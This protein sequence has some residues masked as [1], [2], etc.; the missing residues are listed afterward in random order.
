[1][2]EFMR[3]IATIDSHTAGE[4]TR[5]ITSGLPFISGTTMAEKMDYAQENFSWVPPLLLR[6]PR[7]H[8]DL[9]GAVLVPPCDPAADVGVIFMN[10]QTFEPMCGHA[11]I[12][13]VTTLIEV[14]MVAAKAP[15]HSLVLDTPAGLIRARAAFR[16]GKVIE[17]SFDNVPSFLYQKD[18][19]ISMPDGGSRR[20]D[21]AFGGNF[22][23]L[24]DVTDQQYML[25]PAEAAELAH[26]GMCILEAVNQQVAVRHPALP[27]INRVNDL[28]FYKDLDNRRAISRNVVVLGNHMVDRSPCG[29]GTCAELAMKYSRGLVEL[30]EILITESILGTQFKAEVIAETTV[31]SG[32]ECI[33]AIVPRLTGSACLTGFHQ[34]ILQDND[35]F[36]EGFLLC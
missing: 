19:V 22:F 3:M 11:V 23:A 15:S 5:L 8:K 10:N 33:T 28:R 30:G 25:V 21:I 2:A 7:G 29:T 4:G 9:Y 27:E 32:S 36:P 35:P 1:M 18:V 12:G 13:V 17:V 20:I 26:E 31:G 14:G 24:V 6:E 16:Q 34:F